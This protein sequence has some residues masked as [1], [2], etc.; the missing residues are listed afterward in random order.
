MLVDLLDHGAFVVVAGLDA[1]V[2]DVAKR[3]AFDQLAGAGLDGGAFQK[4]SAEVLALFI[5]ERCSNSLVKMTYQL[6]MDMISKMTS[7]LLATTSPWFHRALRPYGFSTAS[8][9]TAGALTSI[10][11]GAAAGAVAG[12]WA[13]GSEAACAAAGSG[14]APKAATT[15]ISAAISVA[16]GA[17]SALVENMW[18]P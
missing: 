17:R 6:P 11:A 16:R 5:M 8:S 14:L 18:T 4:V 2:G 9:A 1:G 3:R 15:A 7:V 10:G 12:A 13:A